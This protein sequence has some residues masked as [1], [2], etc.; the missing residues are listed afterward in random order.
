MH[1]EHHPYTF[2]EEIVCFSFPL[3]F[4][5][6]KAKYLAKHVLLN[7]HNSYGSSGQFSVKHTN[8]KDVN[9]FIGEGGVE[10]A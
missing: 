10:R 5:S 8:E 2:N 3:C 1:C 7:G 6:P 4:G 9:Y